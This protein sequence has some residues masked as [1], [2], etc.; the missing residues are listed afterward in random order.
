MA[1]TMVK[2]EKMYIHPSQPHV[3]FLR[4]GIQDSGVSYPLKLVEGNEAPTS[5]E[6]SPTILK[7]DPTPPKGSAVPGL[8]QKVGKMKKKGKESQSKNFS[9]LLPQI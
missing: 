9:A 3:T 4:T 6:I 1:L 2:F 5:L 8:L 7:Y